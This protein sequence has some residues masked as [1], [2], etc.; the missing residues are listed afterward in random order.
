MSN[1]RQTHRSFQNHTHH[2]Q[3]QQR[4]YN[5]RNAPMRPNYQSSRRR[6]SVHNNPRV[7]Y[8]LF[9]GSD[10]HTATDHQHHHHENFAPQFLDQTPVF[11]PPLISSSPYEQI[12]DDVNDLLELIDTSGTL[13]YINYMTS[14]L[15]ELE[16]NSRF[17]YSFLRDYMLYLLDEMYDFDAPRDYDEDVIEYLKIRTHYAPAKDGVDPDVLAAAVVESE[18]CAICQSEFKHEEDIGALQCGHE[19]HIDCIK[20][21]L[22]RKKDC[23]MCRAS[24]LPSQEQRL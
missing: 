3:Q 21:W 19:Y 23:P 1:Y 13:D 18:I 17:D 6:H 4:V 2:H 24:V 16:R 10:S 15:P 22:L 8:S 11:Q 12:D 14:Q 20:Q 5:P 9:E 7:N